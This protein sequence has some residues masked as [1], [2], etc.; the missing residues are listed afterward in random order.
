MNRELADTED[1]KSLL[2]FTISFICV[3]INGTWY[4]AKENSMQVVTCVFDL[5]TVT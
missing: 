4:E 3:L 1:T 5:T 2:M